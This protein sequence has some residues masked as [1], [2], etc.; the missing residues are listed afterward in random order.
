MITSANSII[1]GKSQTCRQWLTEPEAPRCSNLVGIL[2]YAGAFGGV[3]FCKVSLYLYYL[4]RWNKSKAAFVNFPWSCIT[5][6]IIMFI[7]N[8][9]HAI[10]RLQF[11]W[12]IIFKTDI[13]GPMWENS[14]KISQISR[15][16]V[17]ILSYY[18]S[19]ILLLE[20]MFEVRNG[21]MV[22]VNFWGFFTPVSQRSLE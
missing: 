16:S 22:F 8:F 15:S 9:G 17:M 6:V 19:M 11:V 13:H 14:L 21:L 18:F 10:R 20:C 3:Y 4:L 5:L 2:L 7:N 12:D 1:S